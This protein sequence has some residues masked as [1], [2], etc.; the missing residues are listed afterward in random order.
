MQH[1]DRHLSVLYYYFGGPTKLSSELYLAKFLGTSAKLFF[2]YSTF[3]F[4]Y[5][6]FFSVFYIFHYNINRKLRNIYCQVLTYEKINQMKM[7]CLWIPTF[8]DE[9]LNIFFIR[10]NMLV[11]TL[12]NNI[13][14]QTINFDKFES[15]WKS[16]MRIA[17]LI[18]MMYHLS[19]I[20]FIVRS[21]NE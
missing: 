5:S 15:Q 11:K 8:S 20:V 9:E 16:A 18:R 1:C 3:F 19:E 6:I 4:P 13:M 21:D 12:I 7:K 2:P 10:T 17:P 14:R